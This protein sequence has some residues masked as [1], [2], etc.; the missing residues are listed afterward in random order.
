MHISQER[1]Q[2]LYKAYLTPNSA[3]DSFTNACQITLISLV[4]AG[5]T[6]R[7]NIAAETHRLKLF[8]HFALTCT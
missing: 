4:Q 6:K 3:E 5:N 2:E 8:L 7:G 1:K